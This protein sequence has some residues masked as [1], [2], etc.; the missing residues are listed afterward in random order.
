MRQGNSGRATSRKLFGV[1]HCVCL[2]DSKILE[3]ARDKILEVLGRNPLALWVSVLGAA[4]ESD[5]DLTANG[6]EDVSS[7][8]GYPGHSATK[9]RNDVNS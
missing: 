9:N 1:G 2:R 4:Y 5:D 8:A 7:S 6:A 3:V